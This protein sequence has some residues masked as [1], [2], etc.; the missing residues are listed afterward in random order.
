MR[1]FS[2]MFLQLY[3]KM[4]LWSNQGLNSDNCLVITSTRRRQGN[5][6]KHVSKI[7]TKFVLPNCVSLVNHGSVCPPRL[8]L[9]F[10]YRNDVTYR[11]PSRCDEKD[12]PPQKKFIPN[13]SGYHIGSIDNSNNIIEIPF[14]REA[15]STIIRYSLVSGEYIE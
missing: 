5:K 14:T 15:S 6:K 9:Y 4:M 3:Y 8:P 13:N 1:S 12:F 11:T 2:S 7:F 10:K